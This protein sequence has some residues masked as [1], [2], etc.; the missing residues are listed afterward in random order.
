M[1][2]T[3]N[4]QPDDP[5]LRIAHAI[6]REIIRRKFTARQRSII[7]FILT[8]SWGCGKPSAIIPRLKD[9]RFCGVGP[10]HIRKELLALSV[11][12]VIYWDGAMNAFQINKHYDCWEIEVV[13]DF[14]KKDMD[15]LI[16][17][18]LEIK[19]PN[20]DK[21]LPETGSDFPKREKMDIPDSGTNFPNREPNFPK[22][23]VKT[24]RNGK[25]KVPE[26][27]SRKL[28][29]PCRIKRFRLSKTSIKAIIKKRNTTTTTRARAP[30]EFSFGNIF[31]AYEKNFISG[32]KITQFDIDEFSALF[33]DYGGE[34]LLKAMR[35]AYRQ[36]A[37]KRNLAYVHGV[38]KGYKSRGGPDTE[39][40]RQQEDSARESSPGRSTRQQQRSNRAA[41]LRKRA[42]EGRRRDQG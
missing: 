39:G 33:D 21:K 18:N 23:E 10:N 19:S 22:R 2:S 29:F 14:D 31:N 4:P 12:N 25:L 26:M 24:S 35:E 6:H 15:K 17:Y 8:L 34:W 16:S 5:H 40:A 20:L 32:G 38:L 7:D 13:D 1:E 3:V 36:G 27:G 28:I 30:D 42:E 41:E 9:F 37:D 11:A